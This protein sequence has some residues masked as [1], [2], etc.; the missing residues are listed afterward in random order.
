MPLHHDS[1]QSEIISSPA[2]PSIKLARSLSQKKERDANGLFFVEG[3][4]H[5]GAAFEAGW[6]IVTL[7]VCP[8]TLKG[9]YARGLVRQ[10]RERG[11]RVLQ[12]SEQAF[13]SIAAKENPQGIGAVLRQRQAKLAEL[14]Q[15]SFG[16][17][18]VSPQDPGNVGSILRTM[19]AVGVDPLFLL[20]GGADPFHP[21]AVRSSMGAL[22]WQH[23][24]QESF[25]A[26]A[27]WAQSRQVR[28]IGTSA[29]GKTELSEVR[30]DDRPTVLLL[31]SEQKGLLPEQLALC[32][33]LLALPMRGHTTS[34]NLSVAAGV[35]LYGLKG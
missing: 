24:Y 15:F 12:V 5:T 20:D 7:L 21:T 13:A 4:L 30:L 1:S 35:F 10:C 34:I 32:S 16:V 2:N 3:I 18:L 29:H 28:V 27:E 9:D 23:F 31:G 17:A 25:A 19:D 14:G 6:D 22:F 11:V 8:S 33:E 26:F